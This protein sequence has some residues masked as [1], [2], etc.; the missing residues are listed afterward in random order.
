MKK[1]IN[2]RVEDNTHFQNKNSHP[3]TIWIDFSLQ[4]Q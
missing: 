3:F 4:K 1:L 2:V